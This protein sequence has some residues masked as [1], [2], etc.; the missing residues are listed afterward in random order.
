MGMSG[1]ERQARYRA[2]QA[3]R[4]RELE[5]TAASRAKPLSLAEA[6]EQYRAALN[7]LDAFDQ[8]SEIDSFVEG[9]GPKQQG[10]A[11]VAMRMALRPR[12]HSRKVG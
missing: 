8:W 5:A 3:A 12:K 4:L 9:L 1:A 7:A 11:K 2:R 6:R 10:E